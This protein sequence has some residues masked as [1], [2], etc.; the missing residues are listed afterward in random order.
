MPYHL[1]QN[2]SYDSLSRIVALIAGTKGGKTSYGPWHLWKWIQTLGGGDYYAVTATYDLFHLK[3]LPAIRQTFED[4]LGIGRFWSQRRIIELRDPETGRFLARKAD[5]LMWGRI[6]LRAAEARGGLESGDAKGIWI[7]EAGQA[8]F[9]AQTYRALRRR[10]ALYQAPILITTTLYDIGWLDDDIIGKVQSAADVEIEVHEANDGEIE[11]AKSETANITLIQFDSIINP[12]YP[13]AEFDEAREELP[14]EDF[15]A[16][17]RGRRASKRLL[18]YDNFDEAEDGSV[19]PFDIPGNWPRY[20]GLDFGPVNTSCIY[21]AEDPKSAEKKKDRT[22]YCYRVYLDGNK[23]IEQHKIDI[24]EGEHISPT[25]VVGGT[26]GSEK[27]WRREFRKHGLPI[28]RPAIFEFDIGIERVYAQ[29]GKHRIKYFKGLPII[30]DKKR[31]RRKRDKDGNILDEIESKQ[32]FHRL[33][34]E[35]YIIC[36]IRPSTGK[37]RGRSVAW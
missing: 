33:D 29:H 4:I 22:L 9:S 10:A 26:W 35:R 7:D 13:K 27:Q 32:T 21:Y 12:L 2:V 25:K 23:T 15:N 31:Y 24:T 1:P 37:E 20:W 28:E 36:T 34:G 6:I 30:K 18:V 3:M 11:I 19:T 8:S 16:F 5:D 17:H 14:P